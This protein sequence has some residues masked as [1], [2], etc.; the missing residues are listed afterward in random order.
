MSIPPGGNLL[1]YLKPLV[2]FEKPTVG[3]CIQIAQSHRSQWDTRIA[4]LEALSRAEE[5][6]NKGLKIQHENIDAQIE[7]LEKQAQE[8][9]EQSLS[10]F[11]ERR[12]KEV[13]ELRRQ[14]QE[15]A[16]SV[17]QT[18]QQIDKQA[19]GVLREAGVEILGL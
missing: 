10:G 19:V 8:L 16:A 6:V 13:E 12:E 3:D 18:K 5:E 1:Q 7:L 9:T 2:V 11:Q 4:E 17:F 14:R 15:M